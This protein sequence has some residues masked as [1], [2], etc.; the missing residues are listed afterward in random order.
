MKA[1]SSRLLRGQEETEKQAKTS[2]AK[3]D[4][5]AKHGAPWS[6]KEAVILEEGQVLTFLLA[7]A[8]TQRIYR[9]LSAVFLIR[10][11]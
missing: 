3:T 10:V 8:K 2:A 1:C 9:G 11:S 6:Q 4:T 5:L 7:H